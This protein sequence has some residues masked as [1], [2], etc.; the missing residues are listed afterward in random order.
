MF[1]IL[2]RIYQSRYYLHFLSAARRNSNAVSCFQSHRALPLFCQ[3]YLFK[4]NSA[5]RLLI[6][7]EAHVITL[8]QISNTGTTMNIVIS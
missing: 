3:S 8:R 7:L 6:I 1:K 5:A 4:K 2:L